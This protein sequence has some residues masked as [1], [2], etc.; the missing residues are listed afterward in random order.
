MN[1]DTT[2]DD[3]V[4]DNF[5]QGTV[6]FDL[7]DR[8]PSTSVDASLTVFWTSVVASIESELR[9]AFEARDWVYVR[10]LGDMGNYFLIEKIIDSKPEPGR[11]MHAQLARLAHNTF[12]KAVDAAIRL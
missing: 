8:I 9:R 7:L 11:S 12:L 1:E 4:D 5:A 6:M 2:I 10:H 3:Q